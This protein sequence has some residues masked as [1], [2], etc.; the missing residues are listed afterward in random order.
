MHGWLNYMKP[1][2]THD[3]GPEKLEEEEDKTKKGRQNEER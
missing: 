1:F 3:G 2:P